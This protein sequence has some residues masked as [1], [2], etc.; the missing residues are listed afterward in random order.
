[1]LKQ[2][3][4]TVNKVTIIMAKPNMNPTLKVSIFLIQAIGEKKHKTMRPKYS[5]F[6]SYMSKSDSVVDLR[7][8]IINESCAIVNWKCTIE[9]HISRNFFAFFESSAL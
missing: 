7:P 8:W 5:G 6:R 2:N 1:M 3:A 9:R 4:E